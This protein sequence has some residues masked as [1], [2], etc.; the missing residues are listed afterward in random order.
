[1]NLELT[2]EQI[3]RSLGEVP[4]S[5][6]AALAQAS[7]GAVA[8]EADREDMR[9]CTKL[10]QH[11][12]QLGVPVI[13]GPRKPIRRIPRILKKVRR[14]PVTAGA[15]VP[16]NTCGDL[17]TMSPSQVK[18]RD[19][20]CSQCVQTGRA[21]R[22]KP[23]RD[24]ALKSAKRHRQDI[25]RSAVHRAV[26]T[27]KLAKAPCDVCGSTYVVAHHNDYSKPLEVQWLCR[28]HHWELH[29]RIGEVRV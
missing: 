4:K 8:L 11:R 22:G 2:N 5:G 25:V 7:Y 13:A 29:Q 17:F 19:Y 26:R 21:R 15:V 12:A 6:R 1:M 9:S 14:G 3:L 10:E 24:P 28:L 20:M 23:K 16:C 27:G 18:R